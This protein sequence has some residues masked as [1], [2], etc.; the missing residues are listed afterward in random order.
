M[1]EKQLFRSISIR[2]QQQE[3]INKMKIHSKQ[4]YYEIIE[5]LLDFYEKNH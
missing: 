5:I 3:R 1:N 4:A 2:P